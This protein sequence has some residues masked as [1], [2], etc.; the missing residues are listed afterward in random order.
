MTFKIKFKKCKVC[1]TEFTPPNSMIAHCSPKCG[2]ELHKQKEAKKAENERKK[3][4][5]ELRHFRLENKPISKWIAEAQTAVNAY[6]RVRDHKKPCISCGKPDTG[7]NGLRGQLFDAG[8]YR[9]RGAASHLRFNTHNIYKQCVKC[10]R[11]LSGN[12]VEFRKSLVELKGEEFVLA[13]EHNNQVRKF[14][15]EYC[16]RVKRI[17]NKKTRLRKKRLGIN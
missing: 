11:N 5:A 7:Y 17:F 1:G 14:D 9:S 2:F 12:H 10:N 3:N 13:L 15:R 8:H 16:E 4:K 6:V